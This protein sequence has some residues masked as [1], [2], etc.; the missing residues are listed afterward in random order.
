M[1]DFVKVLTDFPVAID[2]PDHLSPWGTSRD[3]SK[4]IR[5]NHKLYSLF[6]N[7]RSPLKIM[8]LGCSGGGF[9]NT[10]LDQ[11]CFAIGLEGSDYS[12]KHCRAEWPK[13]SD[14]FL[15]TADIS[16]DFTVVQ[17]DNPI[18]FDVI[19]SWEVLE[20]IPEERLS[21]VAQNI[22]KHLENNGLAIISISPNEETIKGQK[23]HLTIREKDWWIQ[24]FKEFKL[25]YISAY[26][27]YFNTQFI[28]GPKQ[29]APGS[30][31]LFLVKDT[32]HAPKIPPTKFIEKLFDRWHMSYFQKR[33]RYILGII[34]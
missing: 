10:C 17:N 26:E 31:H 24:F 30:F 18:N 29:N 14:R 12:R 11:G 33:I 9:V 1:Q 28:R 13:L 20:H 27:T 2:S 25:H 22:Y 6:A 34:E 15:F 5:F 19:T 32:L 21:T 4:N 23:L 3:N 16:R 8:D 7:N